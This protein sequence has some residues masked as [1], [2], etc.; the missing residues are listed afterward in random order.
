MTTPIRAWLLDIEGTTTSISFVYDV[1]FPDAR[2]ALEAT[3]AG[4]GGSFLEE[5]W[6]ELAPTVARMAGGAGRHSP[7]A[8]AAAALALMHADVK[9]TGLKALQGLLWRAGYDAGRLRGHVFDDVPPAFERA[10][11]AGLRLAIYSSGSVEAQRLLFAH[12]VH[13]DLGRHLEAYF[14]TTTGPKKEAASYRTIAGALALPPEAIAFF[15]DNLDEA[16]AA[17]TAG[18]SA[19]VVVRP[20]N[21]ALP[22]DHGFPVVTS[23]AGAPV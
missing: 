20:G 9:D 2:A 23:L 11:A 19:W 1:L 13:G 15:T 12:S 21:A 8:A 7:I 6:A 10:R 3:F 17:R 18:M 16:R 14:D 22:P 4:D 5:H